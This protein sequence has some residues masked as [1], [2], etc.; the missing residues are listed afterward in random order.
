MKNKIKLFLTI[1]ICTIVFIVIIVIIFIQSSKN[2]Q[3]ISNT[4]NLPRLEINK[5]Y[6]DKFTIR[7]SIK[8]EDFIFPKK[9]P[10]LEIDQN[11]NLDE[12]LAKKIASNLGFSDNFNKINDTFDGKTYFW[13]NDQA[14]LFIY[15]G[16]KKIRY[17]SKNNTISVNKQLS[18]EDIISI[19]ENFIT[20]K[21]ILNKES[22]QVG[23]VKFL[24]ES[25]EY[26]GG[27]NSYEETSKENAT[28]YQVSI[29]PK[30]T[31]YEIITPNF[32]D[33]SSYIQIKPDGSIYSFQITLLNPLKRG[34]TEYKIKDYEEFKNN[35]EKA[36]LIELIGNT[37]LLSDLPKNFIQEIEINKIEIAYL[38]ESKKSN[39][40][41]PIFK[42]SGKALINSPEKAIA[43]LYLPAI[44]ENP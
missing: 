22:F 23:N 12:D 40:L 42:L 2:K 35:I 32:T 36:V 24:K 28:I 31:D 3:N 8:K 25:Q 38:M 20:D 15:F 1:F 9:L 29:L 34:L 39:Y 18:K 4:K 30:N 21:N 13:I 14:T 5:E 16:S 41:I 43:T 17:T 6:K 27:E 44:S 33:S 19:A 10:L 7:L 37:Y 26:K 11:F